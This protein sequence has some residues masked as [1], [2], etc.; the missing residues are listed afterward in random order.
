MKR[1]ITTL[2]MITNIYLYSGQIVLHSNPSTPG[3]HNTIQES[4]EQ[5][6]KFIA[7]FDTP[8]ASIAQNE[9]YTTCTMKF[10]HRKNYQQPQEAFKFPPAPLPIGPFVLGYIYNQY[11][12][13]DIKLYQE[14][15]NIVHRHSSLNLP[16]LPDI[17]TKSLFHGFSTTPLL[18]S[19]IST[20]A[21]LYYKTAPLKYTFYTIA[22]L[23]FLNYA[24]TFARNVCYNAPYYM[25]R[26]CLKIALGDSRKYKVTMVTDDTNN[27]ISFNMPTACYNNINSIFK[28]YFSL[29][30]QQKDYY[31]SDNEMNP[32][33]AGEI[34]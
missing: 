30:K 1:H 32:N 7:S 13:N 4:I 33:I 20:A 27:T 16:N 2:L 18:I 17:K 28:F 9:M 10:V 8:T 19:T 22:G 34:D 24:H 15:I 6:K 31:F 21:Y 11:N 23:S 26:T 14:Y 3:E 29:F 5:L 12:C 25:I